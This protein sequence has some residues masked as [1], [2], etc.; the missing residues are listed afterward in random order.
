MDLDFNAFDGRS[1]NIVD[2]V[3]KD[4]GRVVGTIKSKSSSS[5]G[6]EISLFDDKY[7]AFVGTYEECLGFVRG[8]SLIT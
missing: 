8:R 6:I 1:W 2:V 5:S 4:G 3:D 7:R